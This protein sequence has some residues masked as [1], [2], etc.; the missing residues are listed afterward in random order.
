MWSQG[1]KANIGRMS[2]LCV[3]FILGLVGLGVAYHLGYLDQ[4]VAKLKQWYDMLRQMKNICWYIS[5][6]WFCNLCND[7]N[8]FDISV[9]QII[10]NEPYHIICR[11]NVTNFFLIHLCTIL[12][13]I[14]AK[15]VNC[16]IFV[17]IAEIKKFRIQRWYQKHY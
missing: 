14:E 7:K 8:W 10:W 6:L 3:L 4:Y 2:A 13:S 15:R 11:I 1:K 16:S 12:H 9:F 17:E 5:D